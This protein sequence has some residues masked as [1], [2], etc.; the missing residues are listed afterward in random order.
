MCLSDGE[1][2]DH[3]FIHCPV[4]KAFWEYF[5]GKFGVNWVHPQSLRNLFFCWPAQDFGSISLRAKA[6]WRLVPVA[7]CWTIWE[8]RNK[9]IFYGEIRHN[10]KIMDS[11]LTKLYDWM[12]PLVDNSC[13]SY[14]R[15]LFDWDS[16][17]SP[18]MMGFF[19][20]AFVSLS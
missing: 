4:A 14:W 20:L 6:I 5:L 2:L 7:F 11:I 18:S 8:E 16:C 17:C 10:H 13:P 3:L 15:W 9:R 1:S 19:F 12:F